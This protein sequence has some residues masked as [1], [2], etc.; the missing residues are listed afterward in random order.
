MGQEVELKLLPMG[1]AVPQLAARLSRI[2]PLNRLTPA[3][4]TLHNLYFDTPDQTLRAQRISLRLRRAGQ[5]ARAHWLQT[6]K[7]SGGPA[8]ALARRGEW[9]LP[10]AEGRLSR[11]V[12]QGTPWDAIDPQGNLFAQLVP[13]FETHFTRTTWQVPV[14]RQGAVEL[15]LDVGE[16]RAGAATQALCEIEL[17]STSGAPEALFTLARTLGVRIAV[18]PLVQSKSERGYALARG[19]AAAARHAQPPVLAR[20]MPAA[21]VVHTVL[22]EALAQCLANLAAL[23]AGRAPESIEAVHQARVGWRRLR[24][25]LHLFGPL[26][27]GDA[28]ALATLAP[29]REAL[30]RQRDLDV[31]A[32]ETLPAWAASF[33]DAA[34]SRQAQWDALCARFATERRHAQERTQAELERPAVGLALLDLL[35]W[36][37][38]VRHG[39]RLHAQG[40]LHHQITDW[41]RHR[42]KGLHRRFEQTLAQAHDAEE[43]HRARIL[44]KR[45]RYAAEGLA[46]LLPRRRAV[47]WAAQAAQ[48]QA[49]IG[50]QRDLAL[51]AHEASVLLPGSACAE[52]L[53][54]AAA[55]LRRP[56]AGC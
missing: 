51:A 21:E 7:T 50:T 47:Q 16:I 20:D 3:R 45:L 44:A 53:R 36:L 34:P 28:P 35:Q 6:L 56:R 40:A 23:R 19:E 26:L 32:T 8:S 33:G 42:V 54:G 46:P 31:A 39:G 4:T 25:L 38:G 49:R 17:E 13:C 10:V 12:L 52:F 1:V 5:G 41:S 15:A 29:L 14:R 48:L 30:G 24:S 43:D 11:A 55:A 22:G 9:E 27:Q 37:E 2:A 18:L